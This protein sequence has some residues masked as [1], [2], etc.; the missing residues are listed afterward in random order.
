MFSRLFGKPDPSKAHAEGVARD[1]AQLARFRQL[2]ADMARP[3][4]V[5]HNFWAPSQA[6]AEALA[7]QL[8]GHASQIKVARVLRRWGI[9]CV[10]VMPLS[11]GA[12][13]EQRD[14]FETLAIEHGATYDGWGAL[15]D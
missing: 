8:A 12:V 2:G 4:P 11:E 7:G 14:K 13:A 5:D 10:V 15:A 1:A 6:V 3:R 9:E